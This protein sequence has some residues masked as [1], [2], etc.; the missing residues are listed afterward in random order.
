ML[1][2]EAIRHLEALGPMFRLPRRGRRHDVASTLLL[3]QRNRMLRDPATRRAER[4]FCWSLC[5]EF[6]SETLTRRSQTG[7][8]HRSDKR[9]WCRTCLVV[10]ATYTLTGR[11]GSA[12]RPRDLSPK[13]FVSHRLNFFVV[14]VAP[15]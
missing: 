11:E 5:H 6:S 9:F 8:K 12:R 14:H 4:D 3:R 13:G 15:Q 7:L 1:Q 10:L 2:F